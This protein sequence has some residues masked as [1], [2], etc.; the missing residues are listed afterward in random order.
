MRVLFRLVFALSLAA[1]LAA[2]AMAQPELG[3]AEVHH[4][5]YPTEQA[6]VEFARLAHVYS[7]SAL[8]IEVFSDGQITGNERTAI[9]MVQ[10]GTIAF[11]RVSAGALGAFNSR[12]NVFGLPYLFDSKQHLWRFLESAYGRK[13]LDELAT[14]FGL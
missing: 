13:M 6:V 12:L 2:R 4:K 7:H 14:S 11:A 10:K 5:G 3:L 9:E 1:V 8:T